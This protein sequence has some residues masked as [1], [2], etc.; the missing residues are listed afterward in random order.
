[1]WFLSC[2]LKN[3]QRSG[4]PLKQLLPGW[5]ENASVQQASV[6]TPERLHSTWATSEFG[7]KR[8]MESYPLSGFC[9]R[10][11]LLAWD[12]RV[13]VSPQGSTITQKQRHLFRAGTQANAPPGPLQSL[14]AQKRAGWCVCA[15]GH[16]QVT[17]EL[18]WI[19]DSSLCAHLPDSSKQFRRHH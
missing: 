11:N 2:S 14:A 4:L 12:A 7:R 5:E 15:R 1:M 16:W 18:W 10:S 3:P 19:G 13:Q 17:L 6:F 8:P 9:S